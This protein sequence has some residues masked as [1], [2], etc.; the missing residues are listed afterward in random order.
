MNPPVDRVMLADDEILIVADD[1]STIEFCEQTVATPRDLPL[2][3]R[4]LE[5]RVEHELFIGWGQKAAIMVEEYADYV[6]DGS[7]IDVIAADLSDEDRAEIASLNARLDGLEIRLIEKDPLDIE[8]LAELNPSKC[9]NIILLSEAGDSNDAEEIDSRSLMILLLLRRIF[10][11]NGSRVRDTQLITEVMDSANQSLVSQA[12]VRDF[13]ISDRLISMMLAQMS[14]EPDIKRVY[15]DLFEEDGSEIY[16]KP[17]SHYRAE[18]PQELSFA[19]CMGLAQKRGEVC[20][21]VKE[22]KLESD[23]IHNYGVTLIPLKNERFT[24]GAED[25]LVVLA[26]D[27]S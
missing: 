23:A 6:V 8:N 12:G 16:L 2:H 22:K 5:Q 27:E 24:L 21:G 10:K 9:D 18:L 3:D 26:E 17:L 7:T 14:E 1:D 20:I 15:D 25:C 4:R 19:D 11:E 13:I